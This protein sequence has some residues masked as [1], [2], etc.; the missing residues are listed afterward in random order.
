MNRPLS[1]QRLH[2]LNM[3]RLNRCGSCGKKM[4]PVLKS[5]A[6][7]IKK[8]N[9]RTRER[10][11]YKAKVHGGPGRPRKCLDET[12]TKAI[13]EIILIMEKADY[14]LSNDELSRSLEVSQSTVKKYR[15]IYAP[16]LEFAS[17]AKAVA[18]MAN[19]DYSLSDKELV[20]FMRVSL[21]T[22]S[23]YRKIY[24]SQTVKPPRAYKKKTK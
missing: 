19:A 24:A 23:K 11:G 7:C 2:Q 15:K 9:L 16:N 17:K 5:C 1:R 22:V 20:Y 8:T 14:S 3:K 12:G 13:N 18:L 10:K 21:P 4:H 6:P